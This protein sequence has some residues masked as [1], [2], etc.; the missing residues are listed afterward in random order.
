[1]RSIC[2]PVLRFNEPAVGEKYK[3]VAQVMGLPAS[4]ANATG[5]ANA[6]AALNARLGILRGWA[7]WAWRQDTVEKN[8]DGAPGRPLPPV[9]AA[10]T[11]QGRVHPTSS[12]KAGAEPMKVKDKVCVVTGAAGESVRRSLGAMQRKVPKV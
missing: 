1:M 3:E 6:V 12:S 10:P 7:Q 4:E 8:A 5:V 9:D 11:D 2:R